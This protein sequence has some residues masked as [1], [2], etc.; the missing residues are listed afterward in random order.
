LHKKDEEDHKE[1][2]AF[3]K[4]ARCQKEFREIKEIVKK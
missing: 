4:H 2:V 1:D 3:I